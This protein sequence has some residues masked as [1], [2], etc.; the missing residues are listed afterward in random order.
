MSRVES[1][2]SLDEMLALN[3]LASFWLIRE[4]R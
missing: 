4:E 3:A 2:K 1:A